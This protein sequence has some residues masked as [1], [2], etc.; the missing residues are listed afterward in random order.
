MG[1]TIEERKERVRQQ[2]EET[3]TLNADAAIWLASDPEARARKLELQRAGRM[4]PN[5]ATLVREMRRKNA[6]EALAR[7]S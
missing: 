2:R 7:D 1:L 6:T 5:A 4:Q 3:A